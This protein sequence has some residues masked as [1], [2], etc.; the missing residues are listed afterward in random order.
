MLLSVE[1]QTEA[2]SNRHVQKGVRRTTV[3]E[4]NAAVSFRRKTILATD[5]LY[6]QVKGISDLGVTRCGHMASSVRDRFSV[7]RSSSS[8]DGDSEVAGLGGGREAQLTVVWCE[9]EL[10]VIAGVR[11]DLFTQTQSD[12]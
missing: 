4:Q 3:T 2:G 8:R 10:K 5:L 7:V 11:G 12:L 9:N 6:L 1:R